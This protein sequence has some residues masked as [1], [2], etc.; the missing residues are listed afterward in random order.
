MI[1]AY[2][3]ESAKTL[4]GRPVYSV[5]GF[6]GTRDEWRRFEELWTPELIGAG[7]PCYHGKDNK[8]DRLRLPMVQTIQSSGV[9]GLLATVFQDEYTEA[10]HELK[11]TLGNHYAFLAVH[12]ALTIRDWARK[13]GG[14]PIAYVLE[15]GQPNVEHVMR[16][17]RT[18]TGGDA[19]SVAC[20]GKRDFTGLQAADFVAHHG[21]ALDVGL[22]WITQLLGDGPGQIIWGH[23]DPTGIELASKGLRHLLQRHRHVKVQRKRQRRASKAERPSEN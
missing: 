15:D 5:G 3:D 8:C 17:I 12:M 1:E 6:I 23:L 10:G 22:A 18:L 21:A 7:V 19:A 4:A 20:A 9:R 14:G 16:V 13:N 2:I 11:S